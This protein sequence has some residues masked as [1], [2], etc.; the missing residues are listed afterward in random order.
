MM[1]QLMSRAREL[2]P[3]SSGDP[4]ASRR[5]RYLKRSAK[6][7]AQLESLLG[8]FRAWCEQAI[9]GG[10]FDSRLTKTLADARIDRGGRTELAELLQSGEITLAMVDQAAVLIRKL[11]AARRDAKAAELPDAPSKRR[12]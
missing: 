9:A 5:E 1:E 7:T 6:L 10:Q 3:L 8:D 2:T 12:Q 4:S 11:D